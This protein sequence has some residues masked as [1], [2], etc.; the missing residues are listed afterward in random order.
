M[1]EEK[2]R[3]QGHKSDNM[4]SK[5][6]FVQITTLVVL[7]LDQLST[8]DMFPVSGLSIRMCNTLF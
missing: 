5:Y 1:R 6:G 4:T 3:T 7:S 8:F 2:H